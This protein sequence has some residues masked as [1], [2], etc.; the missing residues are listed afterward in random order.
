MAPPVGEMK[1]Q[2]GWWWWLSHQTLIIL[3]VTQVAG[4]DVL[5]IILRLSAILSP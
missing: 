4:E 2:G 5:E 3:K 1:K